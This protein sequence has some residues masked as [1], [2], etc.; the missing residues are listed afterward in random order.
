MMN[1]IVPK[2]LLTI[3]IS[4]SMIADVLAESLTVREGV[5]WDYKLHHR[6]NGENLDCIENGYHFEGVEVAEGIE[7]HVF[8]NGTGEKRPTVRG[9]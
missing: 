8:R 2:L 5:I 4:I 1:R 6:V 7:Y 9:R 3:C